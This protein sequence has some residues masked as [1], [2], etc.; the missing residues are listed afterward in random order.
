MSHVQAEV[1]LSWHAISKPWECNAVQTSCIMTSSHNLACLP[2]IHAFSV[3]S[4]KAHVDTHL[5]VPVHMTGTAAC[6]S[7]AELFPHGWSLE[8][9]AMQKQQLPV[10]RAGGLLIALVP[11]HAAWSATYAINDLPW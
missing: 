2:D 8:Q 6:S 10:M 4:N 9:A 3:W 7:A 5:C 1:A 11:L